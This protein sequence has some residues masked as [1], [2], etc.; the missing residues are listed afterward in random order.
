MVQ[1]VSYWALCIKIVTDKFSLAILYTFAA[2]ES[3]R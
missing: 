1:D 2:K 3:D